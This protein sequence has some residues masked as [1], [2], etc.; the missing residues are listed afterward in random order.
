MGVPGHQKGGRAG[1]V[2]VEVAKAYPTK[3]VIATPQ[4]S[5]EQSMTYVIK[6]IRSHAITVDGVSIDPGQQLTVHTIT[7]P[8]NAALDAGDLHLESGDPTREE[9]HADV[10]AFKPFK[11]GD[12][13]IDG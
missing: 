13:A 4:P 12:P 11:T 8:I 2:Y 9:R 6:N 3:L 10:L 5:R 7:G 1:G